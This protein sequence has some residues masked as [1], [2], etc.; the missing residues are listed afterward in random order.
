MPLRSRVHGEPD[1]CDSKRHEKSANALLTNW[2]GPKSGGSIPGMPPPPG[3]TSHTSVLPSPMFCVFSIC[4]LG[5]CTVGSTLRV[6]ATFDRLEPGFASTTSKK[7]PPALR[8]I[9]R[10]CASNAG[11]GDGVP[12][13]VHSGTSQATQPS[14]LAT[15]RNTTCGPAFGGVGVRDACTSVGVPVL[16]GVRVLVRVGV[17]F[18]VGVAVGVR[19]GVSVGDGVTVKVCVGVF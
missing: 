1:V 11:V 19:D 12:P 7:R 5:R 18:T 15:P 10:P 8:K 17:L 13:H 16:V 9:G 4:K 14:L 6:V 2:L 3:P